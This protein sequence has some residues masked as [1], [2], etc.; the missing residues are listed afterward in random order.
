MQKLQPWLLCFSALNASFKLNPASLTALNHCD[1]FIH[2]S[3]GSVAPVAQ[4][5]AV[6]QYKSTDSFSP[7]T[8]LLTILIHT[9]CA[10]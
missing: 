9:E 6:S 7:N 4:A 3:P 8:E 2:S 1:I 5:Q 10:L